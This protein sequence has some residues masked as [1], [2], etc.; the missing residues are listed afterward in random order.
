MGWVLLLVPLMAQAATAPPAAAP[1]ARVQASVTQVVARAPQVGQEARQPD[2]PSSAPPVAEAQPKP[3]PLVMP[4]LAAPRQAAA[5]AAPQD[6]PGMAPGESSGFPTM[7][8]RGFSDVSYHV[9]DLD[10]HANSFALGQFNLFITSKLSDKLSVL[11][12]AV[13]EAD[14]FNTVGIDLERLLFRWASSDYLSVSLGRYHT[15]IGWYNTAYHHSSWMQTAIGRPFLFEFED[16]GGILPIHNVGVSITGQIPAG[17][18][19]LRYIVE[20]GNGRASRANS[21]EPVQNVIDENRGKAL[22]LAMLSRPAGLPGFQAGLSVYYDTLTPDG[23]PKV[24]ETIVAGHAVYQTPEVEWLNEMVLI[25]NATEGSGH[26]A[27]TTGFYTQVSKKFGAWRPYARYQYVSA[28]DDDPVF[29]EVGLQHGPSVGLRYD[30]GEF[31]ALK[32]QYERTE[33]R[34]LSGYNAV[35]TQ[36]SFTF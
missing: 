26:V 3:A 13:I 31:V 27:S 34:G 6:T 11:A 21:D 33:R 10:G 17:D 2:S 36:L 28:P 18:L 15:A 19:G 4:T 29:P 32:F 23:M 14:Q 8:F 16:D 1:P 30:V 12:E 22:N 20:V 5:A 25:R 35:A 7:Q 24:G 9:D